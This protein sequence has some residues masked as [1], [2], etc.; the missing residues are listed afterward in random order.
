MSAGG[1]PPGDGRGAASRGR[2]EQV[3]CMQEDPRRIEETKRG[4][5]ARRVPEMFSIEKEETA[6]KSLAFFF[7]TRRGWRCGCAGFSR[8]KER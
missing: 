1:T 7:F 6:L 8:L 3:G 2:G 4:E 5:S